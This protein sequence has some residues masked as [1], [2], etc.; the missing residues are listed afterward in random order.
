MRIAIPGAGNMGCALATVLAAN[1]HAV[2][3]WSIE[4]EVV[5]DIQENHRTEKYL[6]GVMLDAKRIRA[7]GDLATACAAAD[8]VV[9]AVPSPVATRVARDAQPFVPVR[10]PV[11]SVAKGIDPERFLPL[12][13]TIATTLRRT[14]DGVAG[15]AGPAVATEFATGTPT[16]D[17]A[18]GTS[19]A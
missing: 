14:H 19:R 7:S 9:I 13:T 8:G 11:L 3:L 4:S 10:I 15:L 1:R 2:T 12:P 5:A 16:S 18:P 17:V 6:P